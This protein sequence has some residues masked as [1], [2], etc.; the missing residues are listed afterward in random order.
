MGLANLVPGVSGGTLVLAV[1]LYDRFVGSI[2]RVSRL[3]FERRDL[4]FLGLLGLGAVFAVF[5][6]SG[7]AVFLVTHHRW[8][9]YSVFIGLTLGGVPALAR[10]VPSPKAREAVAFLI[11]VGVLAGLAFGSEGAGARWGRGG[12]EHGAAWDQRFIR[13]R[14]LWAL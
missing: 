1:G 8:T 6:L 4:V 7:P 3:K 2:A 9:A 5:A 13:P 12:L 10:E 11:G 14:T